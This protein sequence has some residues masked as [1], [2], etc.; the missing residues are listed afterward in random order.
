MDK[1]EVNY[2]K[3]YYEGIYSGVM[4]NEKHYEVKAKLALRRYF[5]EIK[6][7]AKILDFGCGLGHN[8][9]YFK[10]SIGFD[11][12]NKSLKFCEAKGKTVIKSIS[13]IDENSIDVIF[14]SHCLEH[15]PNPYETLLSLHSKLKNNGKLILVL[16][17]ERHGKANFELDHNQHLRC[18][19]FR[20][21][22]NLLLVTGYKIKTNKYKRGYG[23]YKLHFLSKFG[24]PFFDVFTQLVS[25]LMNVKELYIV[26]TK[27]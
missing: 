15:V 8:T 6:L 7:D 4:N 1:K 25:R 11:I 26:A 19:N 17:V 9:Y 5:E 24:I 18:W 22:N 21:M 14:S 16:P 10:N 20:T 13:E 2:E 23:H 27:K 3:G 12:S